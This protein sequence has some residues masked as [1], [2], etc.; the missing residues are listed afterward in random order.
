MV[1]PVELGLISHARSGY[2]RG[3]CDNRPPMPIYEYRC[4]NGHT[5]EVFQSM[6]EDSD[7]RMRG[8]R[9]GLRAGPERSRRSTSRA[10]ASTR[11]TTPARAQ[12]GRER[13]RLELVREARRRAT[14]TRAR[15]RASGSEKSS[16]SELAS[17][18]L[19]R[20]SPSRGSAR[21][22]Q[23]GS[24]SGASPVSLLDRLDALLD[25]HDQRVGR[26]RP[27]A[28]STAVSELPPIAAAKTNCG[29]VS[30]P[31][32]ET[33]AFGAFQPISGPLMKLIGIRSGSVRRS[34][35]PWMIS[36]WN[37]GAVEVVDR[38]RRRSSVRVRASASAFSPFRCHLARAEVDLEGAARD[39]V[40]DRAVQIDLDA[41]ERVDQVPEAGEVD[42]RDVVDVDPEEAPRRSRSAARRRR[43][44][45]QR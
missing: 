45:R 9:R 40:A 13:R 15:R 8:M 4:E 42:D 33:N 24:F 35:I 7:H 16:S 12:E 32:S 5:F 38:R 28:S 6:S 3:C 11:P 29:I 37:C 19:E 10:R 22:L 41:A 30:A 2:R 14:R 44:R 21:G 25:G 27:P 17:S 39:L 31:M 20:L 26:R 34:L 43:T 23:T 18:E 36:C 1:T